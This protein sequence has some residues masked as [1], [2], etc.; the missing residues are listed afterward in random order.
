MS[1]PG[2]STGHS[3]T[4]ASTPGWRIAVLDADR[5]LIARTLSE[6]A[7]DPGIGGEPDPSLLAGLHSGHQHF[8]ATDWPNENL[9]VASA[10]SAVTGWTVT[11]GMPGALVEVS[12][13][14]TLAAVTGGGALAV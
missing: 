10:V 3:A 1:A 9:Y 6:A 12:A 7:D 14:R 5:R 2:R 11:L 13:W 8:F 4:R